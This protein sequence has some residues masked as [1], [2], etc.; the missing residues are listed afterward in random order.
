MKTVSPL[1]RDG[2]EGEGEEE[3]EKGGNKR[4][5]PMRGAK[6]TREKKEAGERGRGGA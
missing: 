2:G 6:E 4:G 5:E 3:E 1:R